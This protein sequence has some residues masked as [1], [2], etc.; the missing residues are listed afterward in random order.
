MK[1]WILILNLKKRGRFRLQRRIAV[2]GRRLSVR[3]RG[4]DASVW[5]ECVGDTESRVIKLG[6]KISPVTQLLRCMLRVCCLHWKAGGSHYE[7]PCEVAEMV[8]PLVYKCHRRKASTAKKPPL[9]PTR[10]FGMKCLGKDPFCPDLNICWSMV[11]MLVSGNNGKLLGFLRV[12]TGPVSFL[13]V[14]KLKC[15]LKI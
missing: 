11:W 1:D 8:P 7:F 12:A 3:T 10:H 13:W 5:A 9:K 15:S 4:R 14:V 6:R 2:V